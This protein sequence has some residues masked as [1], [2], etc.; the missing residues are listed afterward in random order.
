MKP[1]RA[2][3]SAPINERGS[4]GT[5]DPRMTCSPKYSWACSLCRRGSCRW[6]EVFYGS[7]IWEW[8]LYESVVFQPSFSCPKIPLKIGK[9]LIAQLSFEMLTISGF[10]SSNKKRYIFAVRRGLM[11]LTK[12][13]YSS[14]A[15]PQHLIVLPWKLKS[16]WKCK[17]LRL[18]WVVFLSLNWAFLIQREFINLAHRLLG[19][20]SLK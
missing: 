20:Q 17:H 5:F 6:P 19:R 13:V 12:K 14:E 1:W 9:H 2:E 18:G 16:R 7:L 3:K 15:M 10:D 11:E 8:V 4:A